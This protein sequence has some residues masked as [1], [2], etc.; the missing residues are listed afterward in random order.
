MIFLDGLSTVNWSCGRHINPVLRKER[1]HSGG[2]VLVESIGMFF[3]S[4]DKLLPQVVL[5]LIFEM[6][7]FLKKLAATGNWVLLALIGIP[8]VFD[9][10]AWVLGFVIPLPVAARLFSTSLISKMSDK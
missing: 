9:A 4:R 8:L 3:N 6:R 1:G 2:I 7:E 5:S 10:A